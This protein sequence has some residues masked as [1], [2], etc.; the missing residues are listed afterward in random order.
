MKLVEDWRKAWKWFSVQAFTVLAVAPVVWSQLPP[1]VRKMLP[2]GWE[3]YV[4]AALAVGG[5]VGRLRA[6]DNA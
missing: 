5:I 2:E 1:D 3:P 6:Q 4:L